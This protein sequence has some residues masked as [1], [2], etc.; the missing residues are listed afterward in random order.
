[1]RKTTERLMIVGVRD[2]IRK[3]APPEYKIPAEDTT[4]KAVT[5]AHSTPV[6]YPRIFSGGEGF[7]KFS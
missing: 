1:M 5:I 6:A 7:N 2:G 4:N 3:K